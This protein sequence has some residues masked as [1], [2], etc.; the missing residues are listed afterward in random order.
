MD[1]CISAQSVWIVGGGTDFPFFSPPWWAPISQTCCLW[2]RPHQ[3]KR[4]K[5]PLKQFQRISP[6]DNNST[7]FTAMPKYKTSVTSQHFSPA[8]TIHTCHQTVTLQ[9]FQLRLDV[10]YTTSDECIGWYRH[11]FSTKGVE[12]FILTQWDKGK[13]GVLWFTSTVPDYVLYIFSSYL[14]S[15]LSI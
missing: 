4:L 8:F 12:T 7:V 1:R 14:Y 6:L 11:V 2:G 10:L 15:C 13:A 9:C 3:P 5:A